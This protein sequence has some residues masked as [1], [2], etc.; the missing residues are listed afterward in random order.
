ML[1]N[2]NLSSE[3]HISDIAVV[4]GIRPM[5]RTVDTINVGRTTNGFLYVFSGESTFYPKNSKPIKA[6][7]GDLI[8]VPKNCR[9]KM[10]YSKPNT[11]FVVV[12]FNIFDENGCETALYD[13]ITFIGKDDSTKTFSNLMAKFEICS[14]SQNLASQ[15]RRKELLYRLLAI[16]CNERELLTEEIQ[17]PQITKGVILLKQS[18]LENL[19]IEEYAKKSNISV[20]SFR[21]LFTKQYGLS[22]I[23]FR[24]Q[25]RINRAKQLLEEGGFTIAE[26]AYASGFEN[27]GYFCRYFKK[28]TGSTPKQNINKS[29]L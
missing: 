17:F 14:A 11:T 25:L 27:V 5:G 18:Y 19:P 21:Q 3:L 16:I 10:I 9:Y 8:F 24:N 15:F 20:S 2:L 29:K 6:T 7:D 4:S 26:V 22:P 23:R 1:I 28:A 13:R 12:N